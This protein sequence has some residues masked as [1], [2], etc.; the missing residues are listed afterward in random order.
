M[1]RGSKEK[2]FEESRQ[3]ELKGMIRDGKLEPEREKYIPGKP[4][5]FG[6]I[7]VEE[8]EKVGERLKRKPWLV[9]QH[10][11]DEGATYSA[12]KDPTVQRFSRK[13]DLSLADSM[14]LMKTYTRDTTQDYIQ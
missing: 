4:R 6:S 12:I 3:D 8:I 13:L 11:G 14:S 10:F 9:A 2:A 5:V 7:L 1:K